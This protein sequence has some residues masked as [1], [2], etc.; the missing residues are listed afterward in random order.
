MLETTQF[1]NGGDSIVD[2]VADGRRKLTALHARYNEHSLT[3][4]IQFVGFWAAVALPFLYAPLL[5]NGLAGAEL[6]VFAVLLMCNIVALFTGHSY[7][8]E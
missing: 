8:Q 2:R 3:T 6:T 5:L 7:G 4:P 1:E